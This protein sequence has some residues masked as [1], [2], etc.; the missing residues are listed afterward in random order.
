M[1]IEDIDK[2]LQEASRISNHRQFVLTGAHSILGAVIDPPAAMILSMDV[3]IY[4][5]IDPDR[6]VEDLAS[7]LGEDSPFHRQHG[8]F[9]DPVSPSALS[10]AENWEQRL[11]QVAL[12]SGCTVWC[13]DPNDAAVSKYIRGN[14]NDRRWLQAGL[15]ARLLNPATIEARLRTVDNVCSE[16]EVRRALA[17]LREDASSLSDKGA[18]PSP[19]STTMTTDREAFL[20][21]RHAHMEN[22]RRKVEAHRKFLLEASQMDPAQWE[23]IVRE[24]LAFMDLVEEKK[25]CRPY[26]IETWRT[27]LVL[28][29]A[30]MWAR[31]DEGIR[32]EDDS[33]VAMTELMQSSPLVF[34]Y[35]RPPLVLPDGTE[36]TFEPKQR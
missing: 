29:P 7:Q 35:P 6:M 25:T 16:D 21:A 15:E 26:L 24:A 12:P 23:A 28:P 5:R 9:A 17:L 34:F 8:I 32:L 10:L 4:S 31:I 1:R 20:T 22:E 27:L 3:N 11:L 19:R 33:S 14:E 18:V 36:R 2:L 30:Q 13:L